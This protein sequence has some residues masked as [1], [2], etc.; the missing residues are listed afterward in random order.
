MPARRHSGYHNA[1]AEVRVGLHHVVNGRNGLRITRRE[2]QARDAVVG[3]DLVQVGAGGVGQ[4]DRL[5]CFVDALAQQQLTVGDHLQQRG[6]RLRFELEQVGELGQ[7]GDG[8]S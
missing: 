3:A 4:H 8:V 2:H 5:G 1:G 6:D 7:A